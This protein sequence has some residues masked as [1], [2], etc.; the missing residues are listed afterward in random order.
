MQ[1]A[2]PCRSALAELV[3]DGFMSRSGS[4]PWE[5]RFLHLPIEVVTENADRKSQAI[6]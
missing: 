3:S 6:L 5:V 1:G 4:T 2:N